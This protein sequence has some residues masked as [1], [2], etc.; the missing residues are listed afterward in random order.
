[1]GTQSSL[2]SGVFGFNIQ[3][4]YNNQSTS[5]KHKKP[6][7]QALEFDLNWQKLYFFEHFY[8]V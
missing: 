8:L 5:G 4:D 2:H 3:A 1:M 6:N 7:I